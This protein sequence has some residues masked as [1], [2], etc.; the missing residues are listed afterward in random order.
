MSLFSI[1]I[2]ATLF[3]S[4]QQKNT[5]SNLDLLA[6]EE[7]QATID[8]KETQLITLT[9]K[10]GLVMQVTNYGAKVMS[11]FVPD[12]EGNFSDIVTGFE[13]I[14]DA[15]TRMAYFGASIGRYAN[16]VKGGKF[17]LD[18]TTYQ[19]AVNSGPNHSH[20]G[21]KGFCAV[22]WDIEKTTFNSVILSYL[23]RDGEEGYPGNLRVTC[24]YTL[25]ND[26]QFKTE[27]SAT[28]D[29]ST[30]V[31]LT[32]HSFFNLKGAG[33]GQITNHLL[34]VNAKSYLPIDPN[35]I[36]LGEP[37][38]VTGTPFDFITPKLI[39]EKINSENEQL[40]R[41]KGYDHTFVLN[42][43]DGQTHYA[44]KLIEPTSG[45]VMEVYTNEPGLHVYTGNF[46]SNTI[47]K[48][49]QTYEFREAICLETQKFPN[50]PNEPSFPSARLD[51][52]EKYYS[53]SIYK[54]GVLE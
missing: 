15:S 6:P 27:F 9:N 35:S 46:L 33:R 45:R 48:N 50:S 22:M 12:R 18:S 38:N 51:P 36:P 17:T 47:G 29:A 7:F 40:A 5:S 1:S 43:F 28:T 21:K 25:T 11:L 49:G 53:E 32:Q 31:N 41:G 30:I 37:E 39:G 20:G 2:F 14:E 13:N 24:K 34:E 23:S 3:L 54:F 8:G 10:N 19:L 4:C 26:N 44:G 42:E 52:G 16:R